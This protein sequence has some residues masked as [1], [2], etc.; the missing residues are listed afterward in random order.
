ML[1]LVPSEG[2]LVIAQLSAQSAV[3]CRRHLLHALGEGLWS[4]RLLGCHF[5]C[6]RLPRTMKSL[7]VL[8]EVLPGII[9][10][11]FSSKERLLQL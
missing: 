10:F 5:C 2:E 8:P 1:P 3:T 11:C 7:S 6:S 9:L 4:F